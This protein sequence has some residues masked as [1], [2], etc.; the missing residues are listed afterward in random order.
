MHGRYHPITQ[1]KLTRRARR[2]GQPDG[3][4]HAHLRPVDPRRRCCPQNLQ[5][6]TRP[7]RLPGAQ[8][9]RRRGVVR[10]R[11]PEPA[12][13]PRDAQ[14]ARAAGLLARRQHQPER[15]LHRMLHGR[16]GPC[17]R[18]GPARVPPQADGEAPEAPRRAQR[19]RREGIGWGKPAPA[20]RL[21][22][23]WRRSWAIG[24]YVA[25]LRRGVGRATT[26]S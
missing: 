9:E 26:A 7:G 25:G 14:P 18:P 5:N 15:D 3:A 6:G 13:R 23:A 2:R 24:S 16:A 12:D 20:G 10:L 22:A 19:G 1:C 8:P 11:R 4:A 21:S 17:G